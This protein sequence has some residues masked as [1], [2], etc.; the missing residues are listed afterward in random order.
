MQRPLLSLAAG[1]AFA[2]ISL[3][4][5][6]HAH[7]AGIGPQPLGD[8]K[9]SREPKQGFLFAC[10]TRFD[11]GVGAH[12][13]GPWAR[14]GMWRPQDKIA[15]RGAVAWPNASVA[16]A[17]E[18]GE[19]VVRANGLP[20]H[21]TGTFPIPGDDP[22][23]Q[24][25][26]NPNAIRIQTVLLRLKAQPVPA[27][28]PSCV[29]MGM[30]GFALTGVAIFNAVDA[31]GRDAPAY[32]IQDA[33]SGHPERGGVYHYHDYS[34]CMADTAGKAGRHS[35]LVGY[36]LDGFGIF[37]PIGEEG[38]RLGNADLDA[39]HGHTHEVA[40]DGERRVIYHYHFTDAYPYSIGCLMGTPVR[41]PL[42][43]QGPGG[44]PDQVLA[45]AARELGVDVARLRTAIGPPPPDFARAARE[46]GL[47]EARIRDAMQRARAAR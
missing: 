32:E 26:R 43:G 31:A 41:L 13:L 44:G 9:I 30:I 34:S 28:Q 5:I 27:A 4:C 47:P 7:D 37:G 10:Q 15:V 2:A 36:A 33:C 35:D 17:V 42:Q 16:I 19:R 23:Y 38:K 14:D 21:A 3:A 40:W 24:Y 6:A 25:D 20:K 46:L 1:A 22:A 8:G 11:G 45:R 39:C 18:G 12:R 29:P